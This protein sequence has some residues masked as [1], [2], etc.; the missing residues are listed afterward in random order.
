MPSLM[1]HLL[2]ARECR[3]NPSPLFY[4][5][6]VAPDAV[7][8][9]KEKD[10]S[11]FRDLEDRELAL[12]RLAAATD[13]NDD[14]AEGVLLHLF[15]DWKWDVLFMR[16]FKYC[17]GHSWFLPYRAEIAAVSAVL[18]HS[19]F[20]NKSIWQTMEKCPRESYGV[21]TGTNSEQIAALIKR[22][23][24]WHLQHPL[25]TAVFYSP[26]QVAWFIEN[27]AAE[28]KKWRETSLK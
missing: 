13:F 1:I 17:Y 8:G 15:L 3:Q 18:Y 5:G 16:K 2:T 19:N 20:A 27:T 21:F 24:L 26:G 22:S 7:E 14:F 23:H 11:H 10:R 28:Y 6:T 9:W 4:V 12:K 25:E